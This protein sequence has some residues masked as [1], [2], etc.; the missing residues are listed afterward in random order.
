[1]ITAS[2]AFRNVS[3]QN[4][5]FSDFPFPEGTTDYPHNQ[6]MSKYIHDYV[7]HFDVDKLIRFHTE[8]N[9]VEKKGILS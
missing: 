9:S 2:L 4:Y 6:E 1:M 7:K 5:S 3:T 8:V